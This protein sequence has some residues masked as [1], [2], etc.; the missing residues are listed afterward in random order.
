MISMID[1]A[2]PQLLV[3]T[4]TLRELTAETLKFPTIETAC[5]L[6]GM[7]LSSGQIVIAGIIPP[8][9][10]D[11]VR[12]VATVKFGGENLEAAV[13]WDEENFERIHKDDKTAKFSFIWKK[14]SHHG[15][16]YDHFSLTD[17]NSILDAVKK[18]GM[19][20]AIG[21]L[22]LIPEN[23]SVIRT[24]NQMEGTI[25]VESETLVQF[26]FYYLDRKMVEAGIEKPILITPK[27]IDEK[28]VPAMPKL[29][30][31]F[32][33]EDNFNRQLRQLDEYGAKVTVLH[34]DVRDDPI[35]EIQFVI[36]KESWKGI[37]MITTNWD[38]PASDPLIQVISDIDPDRPGKETYQVTKDINGQP[39]WT[40]ESDFIDV[41]FE[42]EK[43]KEL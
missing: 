23:K 12:R 6:V 3:T 26:R 7:T 33:D 5:G 30:W 37:L 15:L 9:A 20:F 10:R 32:Y 27:V 24:K 21:I 43:L 13:V 17:E 22:A 40:P 16:D 18:Y 29:A 14:H 34:R 8:S 1:S 38:Y 11:I 31:Q 42:L 25:S 41:V 39:I 28:S 35:E 19:E 2:D 4:Q 36:R